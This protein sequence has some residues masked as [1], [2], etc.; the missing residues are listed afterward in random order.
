[1][2]KS[3]RTRGASRGKLAFEGA[4]PGKFSYV[5]GPTG[6]VSAARKRT[7]K[8]LAAV[9]TAYLKAAEEFLAGRYSHLR[10]Q[11]P[12]Y[13]SHPGNVYIFLCTERFSLTSMPRN[14]SP[15][16]HPC[17]QNAT[18]CHGLLLTSSAKRIIMR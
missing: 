5:D 16:I 17:G 1:M 9:V 12:R 2:A 14:G 3:Q 10:E 18:Y 15:D 4:E 8:K 7:A 6:D 13:L 11:T